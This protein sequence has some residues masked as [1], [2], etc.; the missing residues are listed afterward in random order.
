MSYLLLQILRF[1]PPTKIGAASSEAAAIQAEHGAR[2]WWVM[3]AATFTA[4]FPA[5]SPS[6]RLYFLILRPACGLLYSFRPSFFL[7][8]SLTLHS[9]FLPSTTQPPFSFD[10]TSLRHPQF[11][12]AYQTWTQHSSRSP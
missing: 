3:I 4:L 7:L 10:D 5:F 12:A 8:L 2:G 6:L 1:A 9:H 11:L